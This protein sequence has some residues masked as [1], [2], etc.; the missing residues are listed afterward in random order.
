MDNRDRYSTTVYWAKMSLPVIAGG[1]L[2]AMVLASSQNTSGI[3]I[4]DASKEEAEIVLERSMS[5][6]TH[7]T[8]SK[9]GS[10]VKFVADKIVPDDQDENLM[11]GQ[12]VKIDVKG[13]NGVKTHI[14]GPVGR[15]NSETQIANFDE[16]AFVQTS[17]NVQ[18][19]GRELR[20]DL[21]SGQFESEKPVTVTLSGTVL[22][23][24][25]FVARP[26]SKGSKNY[27]IDFKNNVVMVYTPNTA[28][29]E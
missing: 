9:S 17:G 2:V 22:T 28:T 3:P 27:I 5:R 29:T 16:D 6:T 8:V 25:A 19:Q 20:A 4:E 24:D 14:E 11:H 10:K 13:I 1:L 23:A 18:I 12:D 7:S 26:A 15:L 21:I